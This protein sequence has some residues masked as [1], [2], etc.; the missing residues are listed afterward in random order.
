MARVSASALNEMLARTLG[1]PVVEL[2][3]ALSR[4]GKG[5]LPTTFDDMMSGL[6]LTTNPDWVRPNLAIDRQWTTLTTIVVG[7]DQ[8][9]VTIGRVRN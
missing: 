6:N 7:D 8:I 4:N 1:P 3:D 2:E 9:G 5:N